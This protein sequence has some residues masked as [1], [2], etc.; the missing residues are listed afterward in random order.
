[1]LR[2][3]KKSCCKC[4]VELILSAE[5]LNIIFY[6]HLIFDSSDKIGSLHRF[7]ILIY[8]SCFLMKFILIMCSFLELCGKPGRYSFFNGSIQGSVQGFGLLQWETWKSERIYWNYKTYV[9]LSNIHCFLKN[10]ETEKVSASIFLI[11]SKC[12][13]SIISPACI[14]LPPFFSVVYNADQLIFHNFLDVSRSK[15]NKDYFLV[16][17]TKIKFCILC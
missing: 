6:S 17:S 9:K 2:N 16:H 15:N 1:M 7:M 3:L 11:M 5:I 12:T 14:S 8:F 13:G 4:E 10:C